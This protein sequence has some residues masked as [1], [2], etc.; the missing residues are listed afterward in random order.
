MLT[1]GNMD[2][3][4]TLPMNVQAI[5]DYMAKEPY[6]VPIELGFP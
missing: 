1:G 2:T 5:D 6:S 4:D 3:L